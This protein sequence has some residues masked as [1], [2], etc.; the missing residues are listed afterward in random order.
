MLDVQSRT[1]RTQSGRTIGKKLKDS[2]VG[3]LSTSD[4]LGGNMTECRNCKLVLDDA[5]FADGCP[6]CGCKDRDKFGTER[7]VRKEK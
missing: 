4:Q 5:M 6:N 2:I 3:A 7:K 1:G